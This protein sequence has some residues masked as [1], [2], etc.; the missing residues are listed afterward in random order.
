MPRETEQV[1]EG[2]DNQAILEGNWKDLFSEKELN[3]KTDF[4]L[5]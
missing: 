2:R 5:K 3:R 4:I 1:I